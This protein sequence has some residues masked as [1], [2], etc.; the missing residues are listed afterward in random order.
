[1]T[2]LIARKFPNSRFI[3]HDGFK[4]IATAQ[5]ARLKPFLRTAW[6]ELLQQAVAVSNTADRVYVVTIIASLLPPKERTWRTEIFE[7]ARSIVALLPASADKIERYQELAE[8]ALEHDSKFSREC[9]EAAARVVVGEQS[10]NGERATRLVD[11]AYQIDPAFASSLAALMNDDPTKTAVSPGVQTAAKAAAERVEMLTLSHDLGLQ[12]SG[13]IKKHQKIPEAAWLKLGELNAGKATVRQHEMEDYTQLA[14]E[15]PLSEA[16]PIMCWVIQNSALRFREKDQEASR[17]IPMLDAALLS[18]ELAQQLAARTV[19]QYRAARK[20]TRFKESRE[21]V[22]VR[23][24]ERERAFDFIR[25][26][27]RSHV[28]DYLKICDPYFSLPDLE[29]LKLIKELRPECN[30]QVLTGRRGQER[31]GIAGPFQEAY[32]QHL[33]LH[34]LSDD[35]PPTEIVIAGVGLPGDSPI[36]DR[37]WLTNGSGLRLGTSFNSLGLSKESEISVVAESEAAALESRIDE[38]LV[39]R[40]REFKNERVSYD[41]VVL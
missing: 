2:E 20:E 21:F 17:L 1:L 18:A 27:V 14:S 38:Y 19:A 25:G 3:K 39:R 33:R 7:E 12:T 8:R 26:W 31:A 10:D 24:G 29:I 34:V 37:W 16:Y 35:P 15:Y 40:R 6:Q 11:I 5:V 9:L 30:I 23:P 13:D 22:I 4:I 41:I 36:H 32:K 28:H